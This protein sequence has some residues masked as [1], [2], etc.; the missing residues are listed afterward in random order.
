MARMVGDLGAVLAGAARG[1]LPVG[2]LA[3]DARVAVCV[4]VA[5]AGYPASAR[6][7]DAIAGLDTIPPDVVVFHA[8]TARKDGALV[9]AG[10]RVLG[11]TAL[12][13]SVQQ[14]RERAYAVVDAIQ[15]DGKQVRRDIGAR[16]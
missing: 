8:G 4:V 5:A 3:C 1:E 16:S 12:G 11:V 2:K 14:A 15:L 6:T 10:G 9:T 13:V 7:G